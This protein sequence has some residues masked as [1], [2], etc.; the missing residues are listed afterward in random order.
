MKTGIST[1]V[2]TMAWALLSNP[3]GAQ[4]PAA[5]SGK[6]IRVVVPQTTGGASDALARVMEIGRAH[7]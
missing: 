5:L 3:V 6:S 2:L 7:V 1:L 4:A